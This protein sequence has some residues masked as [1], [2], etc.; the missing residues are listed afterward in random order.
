MLSRNLV[1]F[2]FPDV[3]NK[4]TSWDEL[5]LNNLGR[6]LNS[7]INGWLI[8]HPFCHWLIDHPLISLLATL[9]A[10][11]LIVRLL[12]T[13]YRAIANI[14]DRMWL[15]ILRSPFL[16]LKFLFGWQKKDPDISPNTLITNYEVTNNPEQLQ[17]IL[18]RLEQIQQQQA[19]ILLDIAQL[20]QK[21]LTIPQHIELTKPKI[22]SNHN[23]EDF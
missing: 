7:S 5:L 18:I 3:M 14:I 8:N 1:S 15:W 12:A 10:I 4:V 20:K 13:I 17:E 11:I 2:A 22:I 16:L 19:Q 21:S 23:L 6:S 9:I